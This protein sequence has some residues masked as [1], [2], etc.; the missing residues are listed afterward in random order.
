[1]SLVSVRQTPRP[2]KA[3]SGPV[4]LLTSLPPPPAFALTRPG[5]PGGSETRIGW[6]SARPPYR[7]PALQVEITPSP[8]PVGLRASIPRPSGCAVLVVLLSDSPWVPAPG[9]AGPETPAVIPLWGSQCPRVRAIL[10]ASAQCTPS[11]P[12]VWGPGRSV[13]FCLW[14]GGLPRPAQPQCTGQRAGG[15]PC[16]HGARPQGSEGSSG[17][18]ALTCTPAPWL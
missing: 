3:L 18:S 8:C 12:H 2:L 14:P 17:C 15:R 11:Q 7:H 5:H 1:M 10:P 13:G 16:D 9:A 6:A 4:A